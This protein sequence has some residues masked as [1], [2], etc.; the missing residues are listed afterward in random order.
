MKRILLK[1]KKLLTEERLCELAGL[2]EQDLSGDTVMVSRP[3]MKAAIAR[4]Q[5]KQGRSDLPTQKVDMDAVIQKQIEE[6]NPAMYRP[7]AERLFDKFF[8]EYDNIGIER[9]VKYND[10]LEEIVSK[11]GGFLMPDLFRYDR[12]PS[13]IFVK[14]AQ[15]FEKANRPIIDN[16]DEFLTRVEE[17]VLDLA[18]RG[19]AQ[20]G[21]GSDEDVAA[22]DKQNLE[23]AQEAARVFAVDQVVKILKKE[24]PEKYGG[25]PSIKDSSAE[26]VAQ[27]MRDVPRV[28]PKLFKQAY[29]Y[30]LKQKA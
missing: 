29:N 12:Q 16:E 28:K 25:L 18:R 6:M 17:K 2:T 26:I 13:P 1:M 3:G 14:V 27:L 7:E 5:A 24:D 20:T 22:V 23:Q 9:L 15:E 30:Y 4:R 8:E 19:F 21:A 11:L 10:E